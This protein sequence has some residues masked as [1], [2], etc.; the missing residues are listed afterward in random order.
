ML[1]YRRTTSTDKD[2]ISLVGKLDKHLAKKN[3]ENQEFYGQFNT[4]DAIKHVVLAY[5]G[6]MAVGCGAIKQYNPEVMEVK[7]MYTR[8]EYRGKGIALS[9]LNELEKWAVELGFSKCVLETDKDNAGAIHIY[10]KNGYLPIPNYGQYQ[11]VAMSVCFEK[12]L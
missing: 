3:G 1:V 5:N 11:G 2:F 12:A 4:L 7:R 8:A 10:R 9:V 6:K